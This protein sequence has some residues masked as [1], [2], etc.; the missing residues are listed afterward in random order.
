MGDVTAFPDRVKLDPHLAGKAKCLD[1][2]SE[3][4]F[5]APVGTLYLECPKCGTHR[6]VQQ[7]PCDGAEDDDVWECNCG[8]TLFK[9][10]AHNGVFK[11]MICLRCGTAPSF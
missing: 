8:C 9:I 3:W 2:K 4:D 7:G 5:V 10:I 1:C 6:G 11:W